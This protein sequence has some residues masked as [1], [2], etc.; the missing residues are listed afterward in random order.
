[1]RKTKPALWDQ[2]N[3]DDGIQLATRD[4]YYWEHKQ[5]LQSI[6]HS[7]SMDTPR[8][9]PKLHGNK[10]G[11]FT[12]QQYEEITTNNKRL[13][14]RLTNISYKK[15]RFA[16]M[17]KPKTGKKSLNKTKQKQEMQRID[18][19]NRFL[20]SRI[21]KCK[22]TINHKKINK[23]WE[24]HR[25]IIHSRTIAK[26]KRKS[27]RPNRLSPLNISN[28][29]SSSSTPMTSSRMQNNININNI[30]VNNINKMSP[31][32]LQKLIMGQSSLDTI[33]EKSNDIES[34][35]NHNNNND[36][37]FRDKYL[38]D[39]LSQLANLSFR[40][41]YQSHQKTEQ[42]PPKMSHAQTELNKNSTNIIFS[43]HTNKKQIIDMEA[44]YVEDKE[45]E[46]EQEDEIIEEVL[47]DWERD[48]EWLQKEKKIVQ[49]RSKKAHKTITVGLPLI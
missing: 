5:R 25:N 23:D 40:N 11:T 48:E 33:I 36:F 32:T 13:L 2:F 24:R 10:I 21:M 49:S 12:R 22:S 27:F 42:Q 34:N 15:S 45:E 17:K 37:S 19:E 14:N 35:I 26:K 44:C 3:M 39:A 47:S 6:Q 1:M 7:I 38:N 30:N 4:K 18:R 31:N 20:V 46:Q 43:G 9:F 16:K 8:N 41:D 29:S 28:T